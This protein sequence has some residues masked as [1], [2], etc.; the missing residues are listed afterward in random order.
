MS[1]QIQ[2]Y[3]MSWE[4]CCGEIGESLSEFER[5][6]KKKKHKGKKYNRR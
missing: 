5:H 4:C 1:E 2:D 3:Q 6:L